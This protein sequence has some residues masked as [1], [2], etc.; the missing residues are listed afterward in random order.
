MRARSPGKQWHGT[1]CVHCAPSVL[2]YP[3]AAQPWR[4][5]NALAFH[6]VQSVNKLSSYYT[7]ERNNAYNKAHLPSALSRKSRYLMFEVGIHDWDIWLMRWANRYAYN[8]DVMCILYTLHID[9]CKCGCNVCIRRDNAAFYIRNSLMLPDWY[10]PME[11]TVSYPNNTLPES[12]KKRLT[13]PNSLSRLALIWWIMSVLVKL[14]RPS[15]R[16]GCE[17]RDCDIF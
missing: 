17:G 8:V 5:G 4:N 10:I 13:L 2:I 6:S 15:L 16:G 1:M 7:N 3:L 11:I 14:Q 12:M 9:G